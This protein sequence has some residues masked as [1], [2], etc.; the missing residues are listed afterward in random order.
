MLNQ[1]LLDME[2]DLLQTRQ[3]YA[4]VLALQRR[5][6]SRQESNVSLS[7]KWR[8]RSAAAASSDQDDL[9]V[10]ALRTAKAHEEVA[11][12]LSRELS[13]LSS[14][15]SVLKAGIA[16]LEK[17]LHKAA[18]KK[19]GLEGRAV[20]AAARKKVNAMI[21]DVENAVSSSGGS[22]GA[23][24]F[25]RLE[26]RVEMME[27]EADVAGEVGSKARELEDKFKALE[28]GGDEQLLQE[29]R[30]MKK[31]GGKKYNLSSAADNNGNNSGTTKN[32]VE[33]VDVTVEP[34]R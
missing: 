11:D 12:S 28:S 1:A 21:S 20:A 15:L 17:E 22:G 7:L 6:Q 33:I 23:A 14:S 2:N 8:S 24:A 16:S 3:K 26:E 13:S 31:A 10:E 9:A 32:N 34:V 30:R 18:I 19:G 4:E 5:T 29:I 27:V 25:R